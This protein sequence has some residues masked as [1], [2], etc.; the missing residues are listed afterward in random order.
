[1]QCQRDLFSLPDGQHYLNCAY[2]SPLLKAVETAGMNGLKR[3][4]VPAEITP[5]DFFDPAEE[6]RQAF[7]RLI[8]TSAERIALVPAVSYGMSIATYNL[9]LTP[10]QNVVIP[11]KS[12]RAMSIPGWSSAS[13]R[14]QPCAEL[15]GPEKRTHR[16]QSGTHD[17]SKPSMPILPSWP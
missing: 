6:L 5:E 9:P 13:A 12:S 17:F 8:H 14:E 7:A 15:T 3:K 2:M 16:E 4:A 1:M 10:E 11:V